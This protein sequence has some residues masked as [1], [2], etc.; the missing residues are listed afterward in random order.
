M[1]AAFAEAFQRGHP[2]AAIIGTDAPDLARGH[3]E[4]ALRALDEHDVAIAPAQDGGY[5][6]LA[7]REPHPEIFHGVDWSTPLVLRQTLDR[8]ARL[9]VALLPALSDLDTVDDL[10]RAWPELRRAVPQGL[11]V[12]V[13]AA[14]SRGTPG[15]P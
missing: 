2:R 12:T 15:L 1:A 7:L 11:A 10:R 6:M 9:R 3:V 13:E 5:V 14:L 4:A 8:A